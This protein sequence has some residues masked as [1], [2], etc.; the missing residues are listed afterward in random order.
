VWELVANSTRFFGYAP[1][2]DRFSGSSA[3]PPNGTTV[4]NYTQRRIDFTLDWTI[5]NLTVDPSRGSL[6]GASMGGKGTALYL[7]HRPDRLALAVDF[8]G[9]Y[10]KTDSPKVVP[11][12]GT[13]AQ[14]LP[15]NLLGTPGITDLYW[16]ATVTPAG[17]WPPTRFVHGTNDE[18]NG[19]A[20]KPDGFRALDALRLGVCVWW[21]ERCHSAA[22]GGWDGARFL[23]SERH[24]P[25]L[26]THFRRDR[27][28]PALSQGDHL[29]GSPGSQ[30]DPGDGSLPPPFPWGTFGGWV[31]WD[32]ASIVDEPARWSVDLFPASNS[33]EPVDDSPSPMAVCTLTP[34]RLQA[35]E[36]TPGALFSWSA[37]PL[38]GG[39]PSQMGTL[40]AGGE[41]TLT[42]EELL[43]STTPCRV[44]LEPLGA[45]SHR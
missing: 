38:G 32:H 37:W 11:L 15:T 21:D 35:F 6:F 1:T 26:F 42:I 34:R 9:G 30:P 22:G 39:G 27:S 31:D 44:T 17:E 28:F 5:A 16:P 19:W 23:H 25:A 43:V 4:V 12:E 20:D 29:P 7:R 2:Y 3:P 8:V 33:A 45:S 24:D 40:R 36:I 41:G 18:S 13:I 10:A 14:N